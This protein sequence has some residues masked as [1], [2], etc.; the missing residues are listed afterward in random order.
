M[1][2]KKTPIIFCIVALAFLVLVS[3]ALGPLIKDFLIKTKPKGD[4]IAKI[5]NYFLTTEDF[6]NEL[7]GVSLPKQYRQQPSLW[8]TE[9]LEGVIR[10]QLMLQEAQRLAL[11]KKKDFMDTIQRYWEQALL[12]SLIDTKSREISASISVYDNEIE[13][14]YSEMVSKA[15]PT[16]IKPLDEIREDIIFKVK[17]RKE[18][19]AMQ[20]WLENIR[21]KA[22]VS[23]HKEVLDKIND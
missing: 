21:S 7:K 13:Q 1:K 22:K 12:K 17:R 5:N 8:K 19:Q 11:D 2:Y 14:F 16:T 10:K 15:A 20:A 9:F 23:V 6:T 3:I 18:T 4:V